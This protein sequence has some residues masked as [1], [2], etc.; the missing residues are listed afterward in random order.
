MTAYLQYDLTKSADQRA[1]AILAPRLTSPVTSAWQ[2]LQAAQPG[3]VETA[4]ATIGQDSA[5]SLAKRFAD[6][7]SQFDLTKRQG[8]WD[9][10]TTWHWGQANPG[11]WFSPSAPGAQITL[12]S[13]KYYTSSH[14]SYSSWGGGAGLNL[15]FF[16]IG[17]SAGGSSSRQSVVSDSSSLRLSFQVSRVEIYRPW[18]D[19]TL[20]SLSGWKVAGRAARAY[21]TG[22]INPNNHGIFPLVPTSFLVA[23]NIQIT[24]NWG[25]SDL[26]TISNSSHGGGGLS[27]GPFTIGGSGTSSSYSS[28]YSSS[29][30]GKTIT[31]PGSQIIGWVSQVVP[32]SPP[33]AG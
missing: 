26:Q 7:R 5:S 24:A 21:S 31:S 1:W 16:S 12:S 19:F 27:I 29:F 14:S 33:L 20:L 22:V 32:A 10:G 6:A 8:L 3:R 28:R 9:P 2:D 17:G 11:N 30:D 13:D 15:G 25:H 18:F 23:R 4:L